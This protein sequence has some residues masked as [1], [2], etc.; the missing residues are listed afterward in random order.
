MSFVKNFFTD[1]DEPKLYGRRKHTY[2]MDMYTMPLPWDILEEPFTK[3][4]EI[5]KNLI[6]GLEFT[7]FNNVAK[8]LFFSHHFLFGKYDPKVMTL[9]DEKPIDFPT[10]N[11]SFGALFANDY[12]HMSGKFTRGLT[13]IAFKWEDSIF[14][15]KM[16]GIVSFMHL[17]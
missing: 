14:L 12:V 4:T 3:V 10:G 17:F 8:R 9:S 1:A 7:F 6:S 16:K 15:I 13:N 5:E 11:Y 2:H